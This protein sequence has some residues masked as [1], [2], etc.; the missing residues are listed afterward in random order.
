MTNVKYLFYGFGKLSRFAAEM[1]VPPVVNRRAIWETYGAG[2][3]GTVE[4]GIVHFTNGLA[5]AITDY[6]PTRADAEAI[7]MPTL[8]RVTITPRTNKAA[9][10]NETQ[11]YVN[12]ILDSVVGVRTFYSNNAESTS[13]I[14]A[15]TISNSYIGPTK[16]IG[17][18]F[19]DLIADY[20]ARA[21]GVGNDVV[22]YDDTKPVTFAGDPLVNPAITGPPEILGRDMGVDPRIILELPA[23]LANIPSLQSM[24]LAP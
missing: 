13:V 4:D 10:S 20:Q 1:S 12:Y 22:M 23:K 24:G 16:G 17:V 6:A 7:G 3:A 14:A 2:K 19:F 11:Q 8:R 5:S 9:V 21:S 18:P 15:A